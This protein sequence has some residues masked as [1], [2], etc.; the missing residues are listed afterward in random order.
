MTQRTEREDA[1]QVGPPASGMTKALRTGWIVFLVLAVLTAVEFLVAV[2]VTTNLPAL[3]V[4]ALMKAGLI[5]YYFMH[6]LRVWRGEEG[7]V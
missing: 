7:E 1:G 5:M 6:L 4:M 3:V 2:T